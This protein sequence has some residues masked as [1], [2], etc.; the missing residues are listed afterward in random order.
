M[1]DLKKHLIFVAFLLALFIISQFM[2]QGQQD[3]ETNRLMLNQ[4]QNFSLQLKTLYSNHSIITTLVFILSFLLVTILYIPFTGSIYVIFAG[5][6]F[7]FPKGVFVFSFLV[8]ISYTTS[9][10]ISRHFFH[11]LIRKKLGAR[12]ES[13][14][15]GFEQDGAVYLLSTRFSGIIPAVIVNPIIGITNVSVTKFYITTQIGTLPH[16]LVGVYAGNKIMEIT[17]MKSIVPAKFLLVIIILALLP[18][19]LK[20]LSDLILIVK[21]RSS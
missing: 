10:L 20:I 21:R 17:N 11:D 14:I 8:S 6:L 15:Q 18:V 1:K 16:V 2:S 4:I 9:F 5:A 13:I 12:G 3:N 7:G 19:V